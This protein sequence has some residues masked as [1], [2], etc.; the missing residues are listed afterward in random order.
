MDER[1]SYFGC[2]SK[3]KNVSDEAKIANMV[4]TS[5]GEG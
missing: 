3:I 5:A 4:M 1:S 2:G